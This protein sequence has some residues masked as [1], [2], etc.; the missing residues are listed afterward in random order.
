MTGIDRAIVDRKLQ[1]I[2]QYLNALKSRATL[3]EQEYT[4]NF[5]QRLIVER[6]LHLTIEAA[7]D[8]NTYLLVQSA[9]PPP[10]TYYQ[11][12]IELGQQGIITPELAQQLAPSAGLRNR[13]VH[14]YDEI[15]SLIVFQAIG[16]A[17]RLYSQYVRQIQAYLEQQ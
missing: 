12:F 13:L 17:L 16:F 6:L 9:Q 11:S 5:E 2:I 15:D 14:E 3:T 7:V 8:I 1:A 4:S 10:A